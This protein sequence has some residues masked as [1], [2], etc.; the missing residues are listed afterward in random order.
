MRKTA[1][2]T[3]DRNSGLLT[4]IRNRF[5]SEKNERFIYRFYHFEIVTMLAAL[6]LES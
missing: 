6:G 4:L 1:I 3:I 2:D 5:F